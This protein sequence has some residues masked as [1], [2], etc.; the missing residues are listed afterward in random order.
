MSG[1]N[2]DTVMDL[3]V[4]GNV[5]GLREL[6]AAEAARYSTLTAYSPLVREISYAAAELKEHSRTLPP[7]R[8]LDSDP[9]LILMQACTLNL[10]DGMGYCEA[11]GATLLVGECSWDGSRRSLTIV[12]AGGLVEIGGLL[13][14]DPDML[15]QLADRLRMNA[16]RLRHNQQHPYR[17][18]VPGVAGC[19]HCG[20]RS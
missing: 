12:D 15:D 20:G 8:N 4:A 16:D 9:D 5:D 7:G 17:P 10:S 11:C 18:G 6:I 13:V 14:T 3:A 19:P 1:L 2:Y